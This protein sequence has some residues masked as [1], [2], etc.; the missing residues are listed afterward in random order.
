MTRSQSC[1]TTLPTL[2]R[3]RMSLASKMHSYHAPP[4]S[5]EFLPATTYEPP[6]PRGRLLAQQHYVRPSLRLDHHAM[7]SPEEIIAATTRGRRSSS[8]SSTDSVSSTRSEKRQGRF[9]MPAAAGGLMDLL[10]F[11]ESEE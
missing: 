11:R 10:E 3:P 9:F 1:T 5:L 4:A 2:S 8:T 7:P 6:S